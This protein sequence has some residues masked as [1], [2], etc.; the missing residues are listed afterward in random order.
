MAH[1]AR[2]QRSVQCEGHGWLPDRLDADDA[3]L[4]HQELRFVEVGNRSVLSCHGWLQQQRELVEVQQKTYG[5][6]IGDFAENGFAN[7]AIEP[8]FLNVMILMR[9]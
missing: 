7:L 9:G 8:A 4:E 5:N 2:P 6:A 3:L 1:L